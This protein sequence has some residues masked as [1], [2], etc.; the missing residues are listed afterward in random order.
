MSSLFD[1]GWKFRKSTIVT[2]GSSG[3]Q[4]ILTVHFGSGTDS[5]TDVFCNSHCNSDFSDLRFTLSDGSTLLNYTLLSITSGVSCTAYIEMSFSPTQPIYI[6]YGNPSASNIGTLFI[7][8]TQLQSISNLNDAMVE[9]SK[10]Y[11]FVF[12]DQS[13]S[14]SVPSSLYEARVATKGLSDYASIVSNSNGVS[15]D[16][17]YAVYINGAFQ[18]DASDSGTSECG[19][20]ATLSP[21]SVSVTSALSGLLGQNV[22]FRIKGVEGSALL[23]E[24]FTSGAIYFFAPYNFL[25]SWGNEETPPPIRPSFIGSPSPSASSSPLSKDTRLAGISRGALI[26]KTGSKGMSIIQK[27][28]SI[29]AK[30]VAKITA[31]NNNSVVGESFPSS[32]IITITNT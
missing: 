16:D 23:S 30:T 1:I 25:N 21:L 17:H 29:V 18:I 13:F 12:Y 3:R 31:I 11:C 24:G 27:T 15:G 19:L 14:V 20:S 26:G 2:N 10:G 28:T 7:N 4:F 22:T 8:T 32:E 6:Y 5:A 9:A